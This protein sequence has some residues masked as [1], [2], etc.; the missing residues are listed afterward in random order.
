MQHNQ[1]LE[2]RIKKLR[3][4]WPEANN[5][6]EHNNHH[7]SRSDRSEEDEAECNAPSRRTRRG[8]VP[9]CEPG[10]GNM[11]WEA[12]MKDRLNLMMNAMKGWTTTIN[13]LVHRIDSPF[14]T[15]VISCPLL[16]KFRMLSLETY[17]RT[18]DPLDHL[19]YFKTLM[20]LQGIPDDIMCRAFPTTMKGPA[21]V[22]F[23]KIKPNSVSTFKELS[24]SFVTHFIGGQRHNA[25]HMH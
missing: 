10:A 17:D 13:D 19:E 2:V 1:V 23:S 15:Q 6:Q 18:K 25:Q 9:P 5:H 3:E 11:R 8:K 12:E 7:Y 24:N 4:Q 16:P 14:T 22:W 21:R 20:R